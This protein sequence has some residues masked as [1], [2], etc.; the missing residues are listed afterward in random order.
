[1]TRRH[2]TDREIETVRRLYPDTPTPRIAEILGRSVGSVFRKAHNL[3]LHKTAEFMSAYHGGLLNQHSN[4]TKFKPGTVPWNKGISYPAG[5][6]SKQ[7]QFKPGTRP[8]TWRPVGTITKAADGALRMKVA[9]TGSGQRDWVYLHAVA[10]ERANGPAPRGHVIAFKAGMGTLD[11]DEI[12]VERLELVT[13]AELMRRNS[14]HRHG[15][16]LARLTQLRGCITRQINR[17]TRAQ[18]STT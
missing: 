5:G 4:T 2:Y 1:M 10:W 8:H 14:M 12:T 9:D 13:R 18:E 6:R 7:A 3:G 17:R 11:P 16:E 15:P